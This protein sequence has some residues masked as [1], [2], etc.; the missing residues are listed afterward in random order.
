MDDE[1]DPAERPADSA[2]EED[3][4]PHSTRP[5]RTP[6]SLH[7]RK[8]KDFL[9]Q[10]ESSLR[11]TSQRASGRG[12][13][14]PPAQ[15]F[16]DFEREQTDEDALLDALEEAVSVPGVGRAASEQHAHSA[17]RDTNGFDFDAE[18]AAALDVEEL[19]DDDFP[20]AS[21]AE[22]IDRKPPAATSSVAE[23]DDAE[24]LAYGD[25]DDSD[26]DEDGDGDDG[27]SRGSSAERVI[28][29]IDLDDADGP[30]ELEVRADTIP[31]AAALAFLQQHG[32]PP[33]YFEPL[34]RQVEQ[35]QEA[36]RREQAERADHLLVDLSVA[37]A[38]RVNA[39]GSS[40]RQALAE[41]SAERLPSPQAEA[42]ASV[43]GGPRRRPF[44]AAV[45]RDWG[46]SIGSEAA[47]PALSLSVLSTGSAAR[48]ATANRGTQ[49]PPLSPKDPTAARSSSLAAALAEEPADEDRSVDEEDEVDLLD[50]LDASFSFAEDRRPDVAPV[51]AASAPAAAPVAVRRSSL[52]PVVPRSA[53]SSATA[54]SKVFEE[55]KRPE[56]QSHRVASGDGALRASAELVDS[57]AEDA[58]AEDA[59]AAAWPTA[60]HPPQRI[61]QLVRRTPVAGHRDDRA[62]SS[63]LDVDRRARPAAAAAAQ[64]PAKAAALGGMVMRKKPTAALGEV[65][66][67]E[68]GRGPV[69]RQE[70][71]PN[72]AGREGGHDSDDES[73]DTLRHGRALTPGRSTVRSS[74]EPRA[75]VR[76][77]HQTHAA[78]AAAKAVATS[79]LSSPTSTASTASDG[80]SLRERGAR[81]RL[82]DPPTPPSNGA[83]KTDQAAGQS[84]GGSGF[85]SSFLRSKHS[86]SVDGEP[87][88]ADDRGKSHVPAFLGASGG[89]SGVAGAGAG[90]RT[91]AKD[92][93]GR[94]TSTPRGRGTEK[95]DL[96]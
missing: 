38:P 3:K 52:L 5:P 90:A 12:P 92:K 17:F 34:V 47:P 62:A 42:A 46:A 49:T 28:L 18:E 14:R 64:P 91:Q 39:Q 57:D 13:A 4:R 88:P 59:E 60:T 10:L 63:A 67:L 36:L 7:P 93:G 79:P 69:A 55:Y 29:S 56:P 31:A 80:R 65:G 84:K 48:T 54:A 32:L 19:S 40:A 25:E 94:S 15:S 8:A 66:D 2:A 86:V 45:P 30:A 51:A 20:A 9:G 22:E 81:A 89:G 11:Q 21:A 76:S 68:R 74:G 50:E 16:E 72:T 6:P 24:Y 78:Q 58:S 85:F 33:E 44:H 35:L 77:Q 23:S 95:I 53:Q 27:A 71:R 75:A 83:K 26:G 41:Q 37:E 70:G 96:L 73:A 1:V 61:G 82:N 43:A 87:R